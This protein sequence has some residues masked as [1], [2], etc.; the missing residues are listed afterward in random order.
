MARKGP[1]GG[2]PEPWWWSKRG[3]WYVTLAGGKQVRLGTEKEEAWPEWHRLMRERPKE[4]SEGARKD[5]DGDILLGEAREAFLAAMRGQRAEGT[6]AWH[7][8]RLQSLERCLGKAFRLQLLEGYH[9]Q[10]WLAKHPDWSPGHRRGNLVSVKRLCSWCRRNGLLPRSFELSC[11][12]PEQGRRETVLS[13]A[14]FDAL[15]AVVG[16]DS[17]FGRLLRFAWLTGARP[18]ECCAARAEWLDRERSCIVFPRAMS[19]GRRHQRVV[20]LVPEALDLCLAAMPK[21]GEGQLL[22]NTRGE[23]WTANAVKNAFARAAGERSNARTPSASAG[24]GDEQGRQGV[25]EARDRHRLGQGDPEK[26]QQPLQPRQHGLGGDRQGDP[27]RKYR[28]YDLRHSWCHYALRSGLSSIV[29]ARLMGHTT[30]A[31]CD[32]IY[33]HLEQSGDFLSEQLQ[34][35]TRT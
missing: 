26:R 8:A 7:A 6:I 4:P 5:A 13:Q 15:L 17:P 25:Q 29:V 11:E 3:A 12:L 23:A 27:R 33:S 2:Q 1:K 10:G 21:G 20:R 16:A 30:T 9:I 31:M 35:I 34:K 14:D 32:R 24:D 18:Q 22:R 28:M 19:K